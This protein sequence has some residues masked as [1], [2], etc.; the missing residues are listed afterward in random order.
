[1]G[2]LRVVDNGTDSFALADV[3]GDGGFDWI[4][5]II[6]VTDMTANDFVL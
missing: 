1:V 4:V 2:Q 3:N 5:R 6:G